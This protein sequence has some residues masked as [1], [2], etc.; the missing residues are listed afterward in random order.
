MCLAI[1]FQYTQQ[2]ASNMEMG[3]GEDFRLT[4]KRDF[5][6]NVSHKHEPGI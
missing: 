4:S 2:A 3:G 1:L 6:Q 5:I